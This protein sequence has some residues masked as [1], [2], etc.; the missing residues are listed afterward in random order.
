MVLEL[1]QEFESHSRLSGFWIYLQKCKR[2]TCREHTYIDSVWVGA[3][4]RDYPHEKKRADV[5]SPSKWKARTVYRS[6]ERSLLRNPGSD[7]LPKT[8]R[9]EGEESIWDRIYIYL[10]YVILVPGTR[11]V[12]W[13]Y[14]GFC[15]LFCLTNCHLRRNRIFFRVDGVSVCSI[16]WYIIHHQQEL[17]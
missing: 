11:Y 8:R 1:G 17:Y 14:S 3:I 10:V 13:I 12:S 15:L 4:S 5:L 7:G 2:N 6:G 9:K 16:N